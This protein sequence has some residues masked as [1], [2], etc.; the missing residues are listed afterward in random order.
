M[1]L[2]ISIASLFN[3]K[4]TAIL[5]V[6]SIALSVAIVLGVEHIR[7]QAK[8][9][10][11]S[12]VS[13]TDLIVGARS[14]RINLLLYSVFRIGNPTN[15]INWRSYQYFAQQKGV[16]WT[17]PISLGDAHKG[18]RVLGTTE[19]YFTHFRYGKKQAIAFAEGSEFKDLYDVVLGANVA[20]KLQYKIGDKIILSHGISEASF[21]QHA[22]KPFTIKGILKPTGT[23]VDQTLHVSLAG[24]EA[25]HIGWENGAPPRGLAAN[26][27]TTFNEEL[28]P[29]SITAFLIGLDNR[30]MSFRLQREIND[31]KEESLLAILPGIALTELWQVMSTVEKILALIA[32]LVMASSLLGM[33]TMMLSTIK[34]RQR[35]IAILRA[36]G[37]SAGFIFCLI[38]LEV[39]LLALLGIALGLLSVWL[40]MLGAQDFIMDHYGIL[41][42]SNVM[43]INIAQY[44]GVIFLFV[45]LIACL[46]SWLAYKQSLSQGLMSRE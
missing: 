16:K 12:T 26:S 30:I 17:I 27:N 46:P 4:T 11:T 35:E 19:D 41:L 6:L 14:G 25:I 15:N 42:S 20:N 44:I 31:Y 39:I 28:I 10:F 36:T 37:A 43:T 7:Q 18:Y 23:P 29:K 1:L 9:S 8:S 13:S 21:T 38:Q 22:D 5:T 2:K 24:I 45:C 33:L 3:R 40:I 34:Q 32:G